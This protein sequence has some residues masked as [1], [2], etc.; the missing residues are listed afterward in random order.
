MRQ[1]PQEISVRRIAQGPE[2]SGP[3]GLHGGFRSVRPMAVAGSSLG[4]DF[5]AVYATGRSID[6]DCGVIHVARRH[7]YHH[8]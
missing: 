8:G 5:F 4:E 6:W 7:P 3:E 2:Q 1:V